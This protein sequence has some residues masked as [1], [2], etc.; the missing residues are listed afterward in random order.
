M[1]SSKHKIIFKI[2]NHTSSI[3]FKKVVTF[4][5]SHDQFTMVW[6]FEVHESKTKKTHMTVELIFVVLDGSF[7]ELPK[8]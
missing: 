4:L 5:F 1:S 2:M 8:S 3:F 7:H 6:A